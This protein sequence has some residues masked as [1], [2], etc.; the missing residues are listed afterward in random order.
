MIYDTAFHLAI[1]NMALCHV[2]LNEH[3]VALP[4]ILRQKI[5]VSDLP[6]E[7]I[8]APRRWIFWQFLDLFIFSIQAFL[9]DFVYFLGGIE[10]D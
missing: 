8:R 7:P 3:H 2:V 5:P 6:N 4:F 10:S 1:S 9:E